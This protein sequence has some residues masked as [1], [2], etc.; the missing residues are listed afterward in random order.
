MFVG[1]RDDA[2]SLYFNADPVYQFNSAGELRRAFVENAIVKAV[3]GNIHIWRPE[4]SEREVA[5]QSRE[6]SAAETEEFMEN[7]SRRLA[8]VREAL[9]RRHYELMGNV[10]AEG[11]GLAR[12]RNWLESL[13][14][15][16]IAETA[17]VG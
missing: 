17:N 3:A 9:Q 10:P 14:A 4:R 8:A 2:L 16:E 15:I 11:E 5:M 7:L 6:L 13:Q 12:L 1:F